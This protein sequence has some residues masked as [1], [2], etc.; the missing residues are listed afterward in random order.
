M[1]V[2]GNIALWKESENPDLVEN[3]STADV[4]VLRCQKS[5]GAIVERHAREKPPQHGDEY[6]KS[7]HRERENLYMVDV[8]D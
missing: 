4:D 3:I 6:A 2:L 7:M 5:D 8:Y 1:S